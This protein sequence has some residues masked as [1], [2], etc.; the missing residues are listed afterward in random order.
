M[1]AGLRTIQACRLEEAE[2]DDGGLPA[3]LRAWKE[4]NVPVTQIHS[5]GCLPYQ[6]DTA[7]GI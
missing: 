2:G 1:R 6:S 3:A 5:L 4:P 7:Q